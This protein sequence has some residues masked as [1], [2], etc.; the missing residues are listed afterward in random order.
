[1]VGPSGPIVW[2]EILRRKWKN[3]RVVSERYYTAQ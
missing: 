1:M 3:G 2:N